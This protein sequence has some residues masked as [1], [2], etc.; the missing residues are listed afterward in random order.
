MPA[1]A[2]PVQHRRL[3]CVDL[4][5]ALGMSAWQLYGVKKANRLFA[6][7]NLEPL[8]FSGRYSTP[9]KVA[10]WLDAHPDFSAGR[11]LAPR[12]GKPRRRDTP[13]HPPA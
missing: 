12:A 5:V 13:A 6:K 1:A 11:V 4:A 2:L 9:A 3:N 7:Q 10:A 8:I